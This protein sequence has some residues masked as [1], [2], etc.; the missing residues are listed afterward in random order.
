M[1]KSMVYGAERNWPGRTTKLPKIAKFVKHNM[2]FSGVAP[3]M[4]I[5]VMKTLDTPHSAAITPNGLSIERV[6]DGHYACCKV[7][8]Q[9]SRRIPV[10]SSAVIYRPP[11][12]D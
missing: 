7:D 5:T 1:H 6:R 8:L 12:V 10:T 4:V 2:V 3:H 9:P 11:L